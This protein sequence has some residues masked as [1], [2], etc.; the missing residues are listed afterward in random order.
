MTV[1]DVYACSCRAHT[2]QVLPDTTM[3][4]FVPQL[5]KESLTLVG[6][7]GG[8]PLLEAFQAWPRAHNHS[9]D[10]TQD[11]SLHR[12]VIGPPGDWS[13]AE[14]MHL[15]SAGARLVDLGRSRLRTETAALAML[16]AA[17]LI[18]LPNSGAEHV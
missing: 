6:A 4:Q 7:A 12:L 5:T 15:Q 11:Q 13:P 16:A 3:Q 14:L 18:T 1:P 8:Q 10:D 2:L 9:Q 17:M